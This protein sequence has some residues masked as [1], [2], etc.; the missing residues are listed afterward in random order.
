[1]PPRNTTHPNHKMCPT[2]TIKLKSF[3]KYSLSKK[4]NTVFHKI[5]NT[6]TAKIGMVKYLKMGIPIIPSKESLETN[7]DK[8]EIPTKIAIVI[9]ILSPILFSKSLAF[10]LIL[11]PIYN[12]APAYI[13]NIRNLSI[14]I[15]LLSEL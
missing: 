3:L 7:P 4:A 5:G 8:T 10:I 14:V 6:P 1:M 2:N 12:R 9:S 13:Q 11:E 15:S